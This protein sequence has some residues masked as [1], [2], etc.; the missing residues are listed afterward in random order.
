MKEGIYV[1]THIHK[2]HMIVDQLI[3]IGLIDYNEDFAF[4]FLWSLPPFSIL[5]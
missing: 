1:Q 2:F 3:N 4:K 5:W